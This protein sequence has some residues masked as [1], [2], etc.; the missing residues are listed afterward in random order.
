MATLSSILPPRRFER[1]GVSWVTLLILVGLVVGVWMFIAWMPIYVVHYEV[2]QTVR[3]YANQAIKNPDD[4]Q[5]VTN[6]CAKLRSLDATIV[7]AEDGTTQKVPSIQVE[8][9]DVVWERDM[10]ATPPTLH[11]AFD[12]TRE[13]HYP[14]LKSV[15]Q[16]W[17]GN[18]DITN[19]LSRADWGPAR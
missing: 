3:D 1:G 6:L 16:E 8:P 2:K 14:F 19:D 15:T 17:V 9:A 12:Y 5:L 13:V 11:V 4:A 7:V 10:D 18:I